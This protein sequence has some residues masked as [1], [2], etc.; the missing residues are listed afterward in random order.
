MNPISR[1]GI[2]GGMVA[3]PVAAS[4]AANDIA[5]QSQIAQKVARE[6]A[7]V[8]GCTP[9]ADPRWNNPIL[10]A[11]HKSEAAFSRLAH[12]K[13]AVIQNP[14]TFADIHGMKSWSLATK[15]REAVA[16]LVA[17]QVWWEQERDRIMKLC[18]LG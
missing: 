11:F 15:E 13:A 14:Y 7:G 1:R 5:R 4:I 17:Q 2:L 12:C 18:G 6:M 9:I 8:S 16:R 3:G 10:Q